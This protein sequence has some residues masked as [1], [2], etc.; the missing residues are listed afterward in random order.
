MFQMVHIRHLNPQD[1]PQR[2]KKTDKQYIAK[3]NYSNV[4][5]P[6]NVKHYNKIEKQNNIKINVFGY[7]EKQP[8]P[9]YVSKEKFEN[10]MNLL[11]ITKDENKHYVLIKDFNK[12]LY[13]QTKHNCEERKHFCM[14]CLQCFS[15]EKVLTNHKE[16]CLQ[17]N[18][19]AWFSYA[20]EL[21]ATQSLVLPGIPF[22]HRRTYAVG[23]NNHRR[24]L[25]P[26][27]LRS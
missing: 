18:G 9:I 3:L 14:Y 15:S 20:A 10:Q 23:N 26:R 16:N 6:V 12:F 5:F 27:C 8:Y 2:I 11:L 21:P 19:K 24:P 17:V 22:R 25:P 7:E 13:N 1:D 4:E